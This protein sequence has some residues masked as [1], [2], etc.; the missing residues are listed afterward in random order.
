MHFVL[1][2]WKARLFNLQHNLQDGHCP[3]ERCI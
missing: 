3:L 2:R 1:T